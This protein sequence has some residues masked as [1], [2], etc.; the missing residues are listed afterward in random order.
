MENKNIRDLVNRAIKLD[1]QAKKVNAE[2]DKVKAQLQAE[3]LAEMENK[4]LK[5]VE[6]FGSAGSVFVSYKEK[7]EVDNLPALKEI[8]GEVLTGKVKTEETVKIT[9]DSKVKSAVMAL[10][11]GEYDQHDLARLLS[12]LGLEL[13]D[14]KTVLKKLKGDYAKDM[15]TLRSFGIKAD[16]G[17]EEELDA[18]REQKNF[19]LISKFIDPE[20]VDIAKLKRAVSVE[21]SLAIGLIFE[22]EGDE[23]ENDRAEAD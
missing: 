8:F 19:E 6:Y 15:Q 13:N 18:I 17:I 4:N 2:L 22:L 1:R 21:E 23:G 16:G 5:Y 20:A 3:A 14:I 10:Y 7:F 12:G 9:L 11:K